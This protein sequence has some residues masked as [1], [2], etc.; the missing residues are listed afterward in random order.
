MP[1]QILKLSCQE[2]CFSK[3]NCYKMLLENG[4]SPEPHGVRGLQCKLLSKSSLTVSGFPKGHV[5][6]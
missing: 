6:A 5:S 4:R 1:D 3:N 2:F